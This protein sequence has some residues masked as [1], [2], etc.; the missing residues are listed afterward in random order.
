MTDAPRV[1]A[2]LNRALH[3]LFETDPRVSLL[4]EDLDDPYGGAFGVSTG[5]STRFPGRVLSTPL[6]EAS[7]VGTACGL[8]LHGERPIVEVMFAD[9][10]G[11]CFDHILNL[12]SKSVSMY[13]RRM[14]MHLLIRTPVGGRRGYGPTHSQHPMKHFF[15]IPHLAVF[16]MSPFHDHELVLGRMLDRGEPCLFFEDKVLYTRPMHLDGTVDDLFRCE[17]LG[18]DLP[19]A[20]VHVDGV[21]E[22]D[23][24]VI[25]PGGMTDRAL[26]GLRRL[27]LE[28]EQYGELLV[29]SRLY[30]FDLDTVLPVLERARGICVMEDSTA[31]GTWGT[32][33]ARMIHE[34]LWGRLRRPVVLVSAADRIIP[35]ASHLERLVLP[36]G[37]TLHRALTG[38]A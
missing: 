15:G 26:T 38:R 31:G 10:L 14:P 20:R 9:F 23:W 11:L 29:P 5:L 25:A 13:G 17:L 21:D 24:V 3:T 4:G 28:Q 18:E 8:A 12:A 37:D 30:P 22:A 36:D 2:D 1:A 16:E 7:F 33:L 19:T 34:R 32:E 6:S 27:L 35:T